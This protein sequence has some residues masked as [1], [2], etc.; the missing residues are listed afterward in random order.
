M[1]STLTR[2]FDNL[3][4]RNSASFS[5][6]PPLLNEITNSL[7]SFL[8]AHGQTS[9]KKKLM[10]WYKTI[11]ELTAFINKVARDSTTRYHFEPVNPSDSGRNKIMIANRFS[12]ENRL[13]PLRESQFAD[14]LVTGEAFGWMGFIDED[15]IRAKIRDIV[16]KEI[17]IE[18]K[19]RIKITE[20]LFKELKEEDG[21]ADSEFNDEALL[22]PRK[23]RY[24]A[25]STVEIKHDERDIVEYTQ[26]VGIEKPVIF[27]PKEIIHYTIMQRDGR[28]SG[29]TPVESVIVQL[30]LLRQMWQNLLSIHKNGGSPD[31]LF[32]LKNHLT[33]S[34]SY[35]RI[36]KQLQKYKLVENKHGNM[37]FTGDIAVEDL[38]QLDE[39]QFKDSG[40]YIT[41]LIAM[42]WGIPRSS[43]PYIIG[44]TNTK[45]DTGGNSERSYWETIASM[46]KTW[47]EIENTQLWIPHFGVRIVFDNSYINLDV[48][49]ETAKQLKL[50]NVMNTEQIL[51]KGG[52]KLEESKRLRLLD[53]TNKDTMELT[54]EEMNPMGFQDNQDKKLSE[55]EVNDS[56]DTTNVKKKKTDEQLATMASQGTKPT[57]VGKEMD[58]AAEMEYKQMIGSEEEQLDLNTFIKIYNQDKA[59]NPGMSPRIFMRQNANFTTFKFK[60]SDFIYK[61]IVETESLQDMGVALMN[62]EGNMFR[63]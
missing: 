59:F 47:A 19:E 5:R 8:N 20:E 3:G 58:K 17:F 1:A 26:V 10:S 49:R 52:L 14:A 15:D 32:I 16:K 57:G 51:F 62:L 28:V 4:S 61:L 21:F 44:G 63:L 54:E 6:G 41:G 23:Y 9:K 11:P 40:L 36:E 48:Q 12:T 7:S 30:E 13:K 46:Q 55:D 42:Q 39:M 2:I 60:S 45:D 31:K 29:F 24:V 27:T 50:S 53:L 43:I 37:L 18:A 33:S 56:D 38:Q 22:R 25:S 35:K 34:P